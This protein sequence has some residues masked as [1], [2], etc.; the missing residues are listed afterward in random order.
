MTAAGFGADPEQVRGIAAEITGIVRPIE[1]AATA[2]VATNAAAFGHDGLHRALTE[3]CEA[4]KLATDVL[5]Q[6]AESASTGLHAVARTYES[7]D[8]AERRR[9]QQL[10]AE[11]PPP[12]GSHG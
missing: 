11:V 5:M 4:T 9:M 2:D 6:S 1:P 3:F 8:D 10:A 7:D 12:G